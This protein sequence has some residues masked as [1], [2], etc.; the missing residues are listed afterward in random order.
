VGGVAP[1]TWRDIQLPL[2]PPEVQSPTGLGFVM[3]TAGY[4]AGTLPYDTVFYID[5]VRLSEVPEPA[6]P[7]LMGMGLLG[8]LGAQ[9][10][11]RPR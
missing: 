9:R 6:A 5:D 3:L 8:A 1:N 11:K 7:V 2:P 4:A 10:R